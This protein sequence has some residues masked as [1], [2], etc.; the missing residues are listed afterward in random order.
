MNKNQYLWWLT[1]L[2]VIFVSFCI[3]QGFSIEYQT[4]GIDA[5][6]LYNTEFMNLPTNTGSLVILIPNEAHESWTEERHK[7]LSVK[8]PYFLPSKIN[9]PNGTNIVFLNADAPWDTPHPHT[10][11]I[12][13]SG[14]VIYSTGKMDYGESSQPKTFAVG[15][16]S[17]SDPDYSWMKG[18]ITVREQNS[19]G[20]QVVGAFYVPTNEV[21]NNKDNDGKTHLGSL[22]YYR[23]ELPKNGF[24]ILSEHNFSYKAC[25]YCEGGYWPDNKTGEHTLILFS[26]N[27]QIDDAMKIL[28]R[29][30][31]EN[32]YV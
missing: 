9:I 2:T 7:L 23:T 4:T 8:N 13:R 15:N 25:N 3:T 22:D 18:T 17:V 24:T 19:N 20:T 11:D 10:I 26:T 6:S 29:L 27:Q 1:G 5:E 12:E 31:T 21:E 32:V 16:Y 30:A 28:Q 14:A